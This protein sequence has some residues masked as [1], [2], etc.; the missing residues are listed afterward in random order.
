MTTDTLILTLDNDAATA[1]LGADLAAAAK[2]GD[3]FALSGD[4]GA[5]KTTLAR[6]FIRALV[7][8]P[9]ID[10]PSPT[11]TLVQAYEARIPVQH[12]D[13]Y[14]LAGAADLEELGFDEATEDGV[15][16]VE[17]P[18]R[19]A[20][21]LPVDA[22]AIE[23]AHEGDGRKATIEAPIAA[24]KRIR[25]SL[26]IRDFLDAAGMA[27]ATRTFLLGDAS[28]RA[29]ETAAIDGLATRILMNAARQPDGPPIRDGKPYSR[30][31]HLA[32]SVTPFV[33]IGRA[34]KAHGFS[35]PDIY[36]QDLD[37][38]LLLIEHLGDGS[39]LDAQGLP[40]AER[41]IAAAELLAAIHAIDW[42]RDMEAAPGVAHHLPDYDHAAL[43]IETELLLDWYLPAETGRAVR[44]EDRLAFAAA[45]RPVFAHLD[46]AEKSLV[47]RDFHS[48]NIIWRG[49]RAGHD[50]LG[51][52]D[53]QDALWGPS[54]HDVASLAQDARVTIS[55]ELERTI[56]EAYCAARVAAGY[57]DRDSFDAAYAIMAAQRNSKVLGI[58]VRL[59]VRDGK[60]HY[61]KHLPR[62]RDY[63]ARSLAHPALDTVRGFFEHAGI[64]RTKP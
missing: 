19:A 7:G 64:A 29:Y 59:D 44:V 8:D 63:V 45:W 4:L 6:G 9:V 18:E 22:I 32:E 24:M 28:T 30:I 55:P 21:R 23:L 38:G 26:D 2:A 53:F 10:V 56:V 3:V 11:F 13:L 40:V 14:R 54:A 61:R 43:S 25:R 57:F 35:A 52:I 34:L 17:W 27:G 49:E 50:R 5:G 15:A 51:I 20:G 48:P 41:Y 33:A 31:A 12:F 39:L 16:L 58:F 42:P 60:P 36:A 47:L 62:I 37:R 1:R 46:G